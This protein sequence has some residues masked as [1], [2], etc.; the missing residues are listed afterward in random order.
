QN[1]LELAVHDLFVIL[2]G[3][4]LE[5]DLDGV[6]AG[7]QLFQRLFLDIAAADDYA[8]HSRGA[9]GRR[10]IQDVFAE[11]HRF[12]VGIGDG[13]TLIPA[14][15]ARQVLGRNEAAVHLFR[16]R[17]RE[18]PVLAHFAIDVATR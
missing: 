9:A 4:A 16:T 12:A 13:G 15:Q 1:R 5:V 11:D 7:A 8:L 10:G 17:L 2:L 14:G 18:V 3:E 6:H